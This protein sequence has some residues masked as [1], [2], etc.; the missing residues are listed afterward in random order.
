MNK[1]VNN[2]YVITGAPSS[3]KTTTLEFLKKKGYKVYYEWA[4]IYIDKEIKKGKTLNEIRKDELAFQEKVLRLKIN[5]E[6]KLKPDKQ[7]FMER[8]IPDSAAYISMLG[9]SIDKSFDA[10]FKKANYRKVFL[11]DLIKYKTDYARTESQEEAL[12]ID[13]LLE[14]S[15]IDLG[16]P[17]V[18]VPKLTVARRVEF[19]LNNL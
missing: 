10:V 9:D 19:I 3:G 17:V 2:W 6:K 7:L 12:L 8:G 1:Q 14:K 4:R 5:F 16:I 13:E 15:Y 11:L 18:R